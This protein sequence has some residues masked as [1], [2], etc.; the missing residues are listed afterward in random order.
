NLRDETQIQFIFAGHG[1]KM[2]TLKETV[3]KEHLENVVVF[4]FL[5]GQDFQDA[6]NISDCFIVSLA[7]GLTGLAVPSKTYSYMMAGKPVISII[8]E[9]SDIAKDLKE[10]NAGYSI[11]VG[12][13]IKMAEAIK[14]LSSNSEKRRLM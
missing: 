9:E 4:D 2:E 6:L 10:N 3:R 13:S 14:E 5:H 1:N 12:H 7:E 11:Q 8:G